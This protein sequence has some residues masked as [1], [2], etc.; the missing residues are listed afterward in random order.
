[1]LHCIMRM[2]GIAK[3]DH[4]W[5]L[6]KSK[7]NYFSY[8]LKYCFG[9]RFDLEIKMAGLIQIHNLSTMTELY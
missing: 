6:V 2:T 7:S 9:V 3:R 8:Y 4:F 1:M 5:Q